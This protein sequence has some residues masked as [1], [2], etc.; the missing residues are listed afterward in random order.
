M[1]LYVSQVGN[2]HATSGASSRKPGIKQDE[3]GKAITERGC[4]RNRKHQ[5][6]GGSGGDSDLEER[7]ASREGA[8]V[9][10]SDGLIEAHVQRDVRAHEIGHM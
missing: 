7:E 8:P 10:L 1:K 6:F 4:T 5:N 3:K 2:A 9:G